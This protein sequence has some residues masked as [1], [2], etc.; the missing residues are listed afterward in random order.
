MWQATRGSP[1]ATVSRVLNKN[2][3]ISPDTRR[4][5]ESSLK[6]L[7]YQYRSKRRPSPRLKG[8]GRAPATNGIALLIPDGGVIAMQT[9]LLA[10]VLHA[11][12]DEAQTHDF[13]LILTRIGPHDR[14][15]S[16]LD[17]VQVD[18]ILV[19]HG[20]AGV[21]ELL[22]D[23]PL[24]WVF[25]PTRWPNRGDIIAPDNIAVGRLAA[26]YLLE[27]GHRRFAV[28]NSDP[29]QPEMMART[30]SFLEAVG[31]E[32]RVVACAIRDVE[33]QVQAL[34]ESPDPPTA[35]FAPNG[36]LTTEIIY[37]TLLGLGLQVGE[38]VE[39]IGCDYDLE[40]HAE[41]CP[42]LPNID[43]QAEKIGLA[44]VQ[45][46]LWRIQNPSDPRRCLYIEPVL[47]LGRAE[48][49]VP[50]SHKA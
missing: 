46:L 35:I 16:C 14:L 31:P 12:E 15:P 24:A 8:A 21:E 9:P 33:A 30:E 36:G 27:R 38:D 41:L 48:A 3:Q 37:R 45:T 11:A 19:K 29:G 43:I 23:V 18:G 26:R 47:V 20:K 50:P 44:A 34:M 10:H 39:L 25:P 49:P 13:Q 28:L 42:R 2:Q 7:N 40:R 4:L 22:P 5:V 6:K 32:V 1:P 17:P